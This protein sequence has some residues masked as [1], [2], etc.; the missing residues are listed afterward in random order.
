MEQ[1]KATIIK[2]SISK[3]KNRITTFILEM[4]R[5]ILA[6][7]NTHRVFSKNSASSRAIP[8]ANM[9]KSVQENPFIP[10]AFQEH[11]KGM[12]GNT[13]MKGKDKTLAISQWLYARDEAIKTATELHRVGVTKQL[14]NRILEPFLMHKVLLTATEFD[15]FFDLRC[16]KYEMQT[17]YGVQYY[18]SKKEYLKNVGLPDKVENYENWSSYNWL[19]INKG[20]AEIHI[21]DLAEK[22]Y[23]AYREHTPTE[24]HPYEWHI[25]FG[26]NIELTNKQMIDHS[27]FDDCVLL[28]VINNKIIDINIEKGKH[29]SFKDCFGDTTGYTK[30]IYKKDTLF[31]FN[32]DLDV[33]LNHKIIKLYE[34]KKVTPIISNT[35]PLEFMYNFITLNKLKIAAARCARLS[36]QT[37]GTDPKF[38]INKDLELSNNLINSKHWSPF[39]HIAV[40]TSNNCNNFVGYKQLRQ[41]LNQNFK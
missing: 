36:Y 41:F 30:A 9:V 12:Q 15:N 4:P 29:K 32:D 34:N 19:K 39:E 38:D 24:L 14:C 10:I 5:F 11:H 7:L 6:E 21:M 22:M 13:Y 17:S 40:P 23:D 20:Q 33:V 1:I 2:D 3:D 28:C 37:V 8:F 31:I 35:V 18:K 25:P 16:P 27:L 26:D